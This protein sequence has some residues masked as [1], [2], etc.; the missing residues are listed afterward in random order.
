MSISARDAVLSKYAA[1]DCLRGEYTA[2]NNKHVHGAGAI[3]EDETRT[4]VDSLICE[5]NEPDPG[6]SWLNREFP[7]N[8]L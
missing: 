2:M 7:L 3:V 5:L 6:V 4:V 1:P 8:M